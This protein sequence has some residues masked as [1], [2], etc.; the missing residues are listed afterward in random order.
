MSLEKLVSC[1]VCGGHSFKP[2]LTCVDHTTTGESFHV[3]QCVECQML[4]TNPR[5]TESNAGKYYQSTKY[6]SHTS[7]TH[8]IID[9]IYLIVRHFTLR[10]KYAL[11]KN[12]L[13][14]NTI[15]DFGAGTGHF[16]DYCLSKNI[17]GY[18]IE[19]SDAKKNHPRIKDSLDQIPV[20]QFDVITMWHV[21]EHVYN[22]DHTLH[23]LKNLLTNS[24]TIF[25]AVPNWQSYDATL[26]KNY[27]AAYDVPRH[28]WHFSQKNMTTLLAKQ[29]FKLLDIVPMKL[30]AYYVSQLSEKYKN[31]GTLNLKHML[32]AFWISVVSNFKATRNKNYSS[33]IYIAGK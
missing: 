21:L 15:L 18:G 31:N 9:R 19:P 22:L 16:L 23:K 3:E 4:A 8:G 13:K 26:Y 33:L 29:G 14:T 11:I 17:N 28:L 27:W 30:D 10:W 12:N 1:P 24:G 20:T 6:I 5:P 2:F 25:I 7:N 32:R